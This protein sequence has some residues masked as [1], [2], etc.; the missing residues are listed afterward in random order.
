MNTLC[1]NDLNTPFKT[2]QTLYQSYSTLQTNHTLESI[3]FDTFA[4]LGLPITETDNIRESFNNIILKYYPNELS[5][6]SSFINQVLFKSSNHVS[7]FELP[8]GNSRVDLCK[9][10]G[11]SVAFEIKTDLDNL[12]R[13]DKQLSDYLEVFEEVFIICSSNKVQEIERKAVSN[14]G[15]Y[16]YS[17]SKHG[18]YK[19]V[20]CKQATRS[21]N[22]NAAKQLNVLRK[23]ELVS[24]FSIP[25]QKNRED[26]ISLILSEHSSTQ[27]N[28]LFK[29]AIKSR[30]QSQWD[31]LKNHSLEIFEIDYQ[32]FFK[33]TVSPELIYG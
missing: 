30:Y 16:T 8:I 3:L 2:A 26:M 20:L 29:C 19:F 1:K 24:F 15:I 14:C 25:W 32:W 33:N 23:Q 10:D 13:L 12:S 27:V 9:I 4:S 5:I 31:F 22:L 6:K 17:I 21:Q 11:S 18:N 7:I 28:N